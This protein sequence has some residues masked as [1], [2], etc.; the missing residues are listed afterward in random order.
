MKCSRAILAFLM[1]FVAVNGYAKPPSQRNSQEKKSDNAPPWSKNLLENQKSLAFLNK[2]AIVPVQ[3]VSRDGDKLTAHFLSPTM[4]KEI[5]F[6]VPPNKDNAFFKID[7]DWEKEIGRR[8]FFKKFKNDF[9]LILYVADQ[10][11]YI[12]EAH[13]FK[14]WESIKASFSQNQDKI[15]E[16]LDFLPY[17]T[18]MGM[19]P[20][21]FASIKNDKAYWLFLVPVSGP[22]DPTDSDGFELGEGTLVQRRLKS[23]DGFEFRVLDHGVFTIR[24]DC[25]FGTVEI[26]NPRLRVANISLLGDVKSRLKIVEKEY[27]LSKMQTVFW[28]CFYDKE[29]KNVWRIVEMGGEEPKNGNGGNGGGGKNKN[30]K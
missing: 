30:K 13:Q 16:S 9:W 20:V 24:K 28:L 18:K 22:W 10:D 12:Y 6:R 19:M 14:Y 27:F 15:S 4:T 7:H 25:V 8:E 5:S 2:L 21:H 17:W 29:S 23:A 1:L 26:K 3:F 11:N